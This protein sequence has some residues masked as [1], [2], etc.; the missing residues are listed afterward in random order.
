MSL[1]REVCVIKDGYHYGPPDCYHM[2][3]ED[4]QGEIKPWGWTAQQEIFEQ[5]A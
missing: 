4:E 2:Q 5:R 1:A 3:T